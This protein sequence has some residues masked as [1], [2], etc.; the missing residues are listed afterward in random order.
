MKNIFIM[1]GII[2]LF[3]F[4]KF[5]WDTYLTDNTEKRWRKFREENPDEDHADV[6]V[7][8]LNIPASK[9]RIKIIARMITWIGLAVLV[10]AI[11]ARI[12]GIPLSDFLVLALAIAPLALL[13]FQLRNPQNGSIIFSRYRTIF[14]L[15][16][17]L[18]LIAL[19]I[20]LIIY[21]L[22]NGFWK[23]VIYFLICMLI[24]GPY[25]GC[26]KV[27]LRSDIYVIV[28]LIAGI[29]AFFYIAVF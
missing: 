17:I 28:F 14:K 3:L 2:F 1:L 22:N 8:V 12:S 13:W 21:G 27:T 15:V 9:Q 24:Q 26:L 7:A 5:I 25:Y 29:L 16:Y 18:C 23:T 11:A 10:A 4:I 19:L 20:G 6:D